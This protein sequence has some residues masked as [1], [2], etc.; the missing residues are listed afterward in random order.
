MKWS[1][2]DNHIVLQIIFETFK[3]EVW[4]I[5]INQRFRFRF[6]ENS[7]EYGM[8]HMVMITKTGFKRLSIFKRNLSVIIRLVKELLPLN[9]V[10]NLI[11][12][13]SSSLSCKRFR[14]VLLC[15]RLKSP[16]IIY[17]SKCFVKWPMRFVKK[18]RKN[19][20]FCEGGRYVLQ[21][22]SLSSSLSQMEALE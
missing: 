1:V 11:I 21:A 20:L 4:K 6:L 14:V 16:I 7:F 19:L 22:I 9:Q 5:S 12:L 8:D 18:F 3:I 13:Y 10:C 15:W 17:L 2:T